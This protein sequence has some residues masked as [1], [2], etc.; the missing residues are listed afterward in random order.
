MRSRGASRFSSQAGAGDADTALPFTGSQHSD[1]LVWHPEPARSQHRRDDRFQRLQSL[2]RIDLGID[3]GG[4]L[5]RMPEPDRHLPKVAS[6]AKRRERA[7]VPQHVRR[8]SS[9][10]QRGTCRSGAAGVFAQDVLKSRA[11]HGLASSGQEHFRAA[12]LASQGKPGA[13]RHPDFL[14][15]QQGALHAAPQ[16]WGRGDASMAEGIPR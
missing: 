12:R 14:P 2:G 4:L 16:R 5:A 11:S 7:R 8:Y 3:L 6:P 9:A 10:R 1:Q 13:E 15:E